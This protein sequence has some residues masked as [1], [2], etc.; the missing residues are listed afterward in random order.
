MSLILRLLL[1]IL[2]T[3][4]PAVAVVTYMQW[5]LRGRMLAAVHEDALTLASLAVSEQDEV[6]E[7]A[8]NLMMALD[9]M[10]R[11]DV[12]ATVC[13]RLP[14]PVEP[15]YARYAA[16]AIMAADGGILCATGGTHADDLAAIVAGRHR[17]ETAPVGF[18]VD[19]RRRWRDGYV[20]PLLY[21]LHGAAG[22]TDGVMVLLLDLDWLDTA[23]RDRPLPADATL[24]AVDRSGNV[25]ARVPGPAT[26]DSATP[27]ADSFP[28]LTRLGG[29]GTVEMPGVNGVLRVFGFAATDTGDLFVAVGL[30]R[31]AATAAI[32]RTT[33]WGVA[34]IAL[35]QSLAF[36]IAWIGHRR[37]V[38]APLRRLGM[39]ARR[40][41]EGDSAARVGPMN[42]PPELRGLGEA[43]DRM[44]DSLA[45]R[46]RDLRD[47]YRVAEDANTVKSR[48]LAAAGHDLRQPLQAI[49]LA[50]EALR[51]TVSEPPQHRM[52]DLIDRGS[53]KL[54]RALDTLLQ[55]SMQR[56]HRP[57]PRHRVFPVRDLLDEVADEWTL[58]ARDK[59]LELRV[60]PCTLEVDSDRDMLATIVNNL[61]ANAVRYTDRGRI[62]VG[63]RRS[64][65]LVSI[66]VLDTGIGIAPEM[67]DTIFEEFRQVSSS[68]REGFG[69]GLAIV[70]RTADLLGHRMTVDSRPGRGSCF[71]IHV[72]RAHPPGRKT[73]PEATAAGAVNRMP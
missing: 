62:V 11:P 7:G 42:A 54:G 47:A 48:L 2:L 56:F 57:E 58:P 32:D 19:E 34:V 60:L 44:A 6:L 3:L 45:Q 25:L 35:A 17:P 20:L 10:L 52:L 18:T 70:R 69:L 33:L 8:R 51:T 28:V 37:L 65:T 64:A 38:L 12:A 68:R 50:T 63:C 31:A 43:F 26:A 73:A 15:E 53:R 49:A 36:A 55:A 24:I 40:W 59:G 16:I 5:D 66:S 21:P 39:A 14:P 30:N 27:A 67:L 22:E 9:A 72:P 13:D 29:S 61:V 71:T 41:R 4:L 46:E 1:V 23:L